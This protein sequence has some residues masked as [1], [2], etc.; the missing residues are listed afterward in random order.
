MATSRHLQDTSS[1]PSYW[2]D[3]ANNI[4]QT[5]LGPNLCQKCTYQSDAM[6]L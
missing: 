6:R 2:A 1:S 5:P 3:V 4:F